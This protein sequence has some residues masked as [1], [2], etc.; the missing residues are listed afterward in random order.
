MTLR[1]KPLHPL[2]VAEADG[3]DLRQPLDAKT[4]KEIEA[5]MSVKKQP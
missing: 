4:T 5:A 1:L 2:F 3:V